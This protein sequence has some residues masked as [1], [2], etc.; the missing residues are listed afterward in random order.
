V[1]GPEKDLREFYETSY[2][3][4][5]AV[6]PLLEADDFMYGQVIGE[7][8]PYLRA[9][10]RALD[11][12]CNDG[13][14]SLFM[15]RRGCRVL[16]VDLAENAV[17]TAR[18][19]A[20]EHRVERAEFR[21]IDFLREWE[22][23]GAF[24]LVLCSHVIEHVPNDGA[25]LRK[26]A[27]SLKPGGALLLLTPTVHSIL[28][29][30]HRWMGKALPF[31]AEVGHLRRYEKAGLSALA[32]GAGLSVERVCFLDS[33][34]RELCIIPKPLRKAQAVLSLPGVRTAFNALDRTLARFL[35]PATICLHARRDA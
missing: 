28:Y 7:L 10:V 32:R 14:M 20:E 31:D 22:E 16:G 25:F 24:D 6:A 35:F 34:L 15:A 17:A 30:S 13:A 5:G 8:A 1:S 26:I 21:R 9:G 33:P 4:G 23:E 11:L 3:R 27:F 12:G 18:R 2:E 29:S 19:S